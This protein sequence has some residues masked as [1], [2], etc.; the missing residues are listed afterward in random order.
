MSEVVVELF[1]QATFG[2]SP[3]GRFAAVADSAV[4]SSRLTLLVVLFIGGFYLAT[5]RTGHY[6]GDD[7]SIYIQHAKNLA[8][9]VDYSTTGYIYLPPYVGPDSY[10]PVFPAMLAPVIWL[11]GL[12]FTALKV[13]IVLVFMV[14][15]LLLVQ[16]VKGFMPANWQIAL[17]ALIGFN[18]YF[19]SFKDYIVS[20]IPFL[21]AA[22]LSIYLV[23]KFYE[24]EIVGW[25]K[26]GY[27]L[28]T[29]AS[30]YVAYGTRSIGLVLLPC[31]VLYDLIRNRKPTLYAAGVVTLTILLAV[32]Q[33]YLLRS[34]R[35]Y[36]Q[37]VQP[38][39]QNF[40][41]NWMVFISQNLPRYTTSLTQIWDNGYGKLPR[42]V[43]TVVVFGLA[44]VGYMAQVR[45]KAG[46]IEL[47]VAVYTI[48]IVIVPMDGGIRYLLPVVP[49]YIFY[50]LQCIRALPQTKGLR[51]AVVA[52]IAVAVAATYAAGYS[53]Q[54]FDE[55]PNSVTKAEAVEFF[56]YVNRQ[57][58]EN[59]VIIFTK[60]RALALFTGR[61]SS[62]YPL[63]LED[64]QIWEYFA[65]IKATYIVVGPK[66]IEP[67]EQE[68]L[69][70]FVG[71]HSAFVRQEYSN[72]GFQVYRITGL[73]KA[74]QSLA[75]I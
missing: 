65:R 14:A 48:C 4:K 53:K 27:V 7:F 16:V 2:N 60:P 20:E 45:K 59:D 25:R 31:L 43:M 13:E 23:Q 21:V 63:M 17:L 38:D 68:F 50:S 70:K 19:W 18:P 1:D 9:G 5:I 44:A 40:L 8:Q 24:S 57:T 51:S 67:F 10:P 11:F 64:K 6:W 12:N 74:E 35:N 46:F 41:Y 34:D 54:N 42:I 61:K 56:D 71:R 72:A 36:V 28:A 33:S 39:S 29:G 49:F 47:F 58:T 30:F 69:T 37:I 73:P 15:L 26:F 52:F 32:L 62:F 22:Y 55:I 75:G 3:S 66:G